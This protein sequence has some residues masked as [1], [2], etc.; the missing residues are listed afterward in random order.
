MISSLQSMRIN[1]IKEKTVQT[2]SKAEK[3]TACTTSKSEGNKVY[4]ILFAH[5]A[6]ENNILYKIIQKTSRE[7]DIAQSKVNKHLFFNNNIYFF[8]FLQVL[9]NEQIAEGIELQEKELV[10]DYSD[11]LVNMN[12]IIEEQQNQI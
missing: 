2:T 5:I 3:T 10:N 4:E 1:Q 11:K 8:L 6:E 7:R 12:R 9:I